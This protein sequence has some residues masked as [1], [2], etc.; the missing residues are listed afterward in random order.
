MDYLL[1]THKLPAVVVPTDWQ[2]S[3]LGKSLKNF[4]D[5]HSPKTYSTPKGIEDVSAY[6]H[7]FAELMGH[8]WSGDELAKLAGGNLLRVFSEVSCQG[9]K[10]LV[11]CSMLL[12]FRSSIVSI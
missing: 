8:G 12:P 9:E 5:S 1:H 6:P 2:I 10:M 7:L 11:C 4:L 3:L